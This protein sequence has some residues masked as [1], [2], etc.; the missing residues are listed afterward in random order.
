[1]WILVKSA[2]CHM[3]FLFSSMVGIFCGLF[4]EGFPHPPLFCSAHSGNN[5]LKAEQN[6]VP[7]KRLIGLRC[8]CSLGLY[9]SNVQCVTVSVLTG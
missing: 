2:V 3:F 9:A 1:M 7:R 4:E 6:V 5:R 8:V